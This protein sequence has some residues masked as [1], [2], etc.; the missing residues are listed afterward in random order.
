LRGG[1]AE[2]EGGGDDEGFGIVDAAQ[3]RGDVL[4]GV[5]NVAVCAGQEEEEEEECQTNATY[6]VL[7]LC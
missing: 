4:L 5:K 2:Y 6:A 1:A 7:R 3:G